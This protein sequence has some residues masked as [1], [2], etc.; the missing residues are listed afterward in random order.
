LAKWD[1]E[2]EPKQ[3]MENSREES[4]EAMQ[5]TDSNEESEEESKRVGSESPNLASE[6]HKP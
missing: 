3:V 2:F 4:K 1:K 6:Y 5:A